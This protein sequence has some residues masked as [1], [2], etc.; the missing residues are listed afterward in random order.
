MA[1]TTIPGL[2]AE[3]AQADPHHVALVVHDGPALTYA[4]WDRRSNDVARG[5]VGR[6]VRP[7]DRV[8]LYFDNAHWID[9]AACYVGVHKAGAV[10]VP[11]SP[12]FKP[13][14]LA[15]ALGHAEVS[16]VVVP[17]DLRLDTGV[18]T[19]ITVDE[20][21]L[22]G[23]DSDAPDRAREDDLAEII[24]TSG[25][26]S[27]PKGVAC[28]HRNLLVHDLPPDT[29]TPPVFLHAFP[30]GTNAGQECLRI[31]LRRTATA[32]V[33]RVFDPDALCAA[34]DEHRVRRLQLVPSMAQLIV[35]S[36]AAA[37]HD[38]SSVA[39]VILSSSPAQPDLWG[40]LAAA[41]P[42]ASLFNAYAL[43]EGG[44]ARTLALYDPARP[45]SVGRPVGETELRIVD[46]AGDDVVAGAT[47][48]VWLRRPG[49]PHREYYKNPVAT[50]SAFA[51]DWLRTGDAGYVDG[52]GNLHLVDRLKD[53]IITGGLNVSSLEVERALTAHPAV[54]DA[55]VFGVPHLVLGQDVAAAVVLREDAGARSLQSFVRERLAEHKVPHRIFIV[56]ALPRNESGKVMKRELRERFAAA[57]S[58]PPPLADARDPLD[59]LQASI[60]AIWCDVLGTDRVAVDD[61]FFSLGGESLAATQVAARL[62]D[63]FE[64]DLPATAVFEHPTV[65]ELAVAVTQL[66]DAVHAT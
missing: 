60:A 47:G 10:A 54:A 29:P 1:P 35:D 24:Y 62:R 19:A 34:V 8:A 37:R 2:L 3:R 23:G 56:D 22:A 51:G 38:V 55:A 16:L 59:P 33:L 41:F 9:Y 66:R 7:G 58:A 25:T 27:D 49:A 5:L 57:E 12:R 30:V 11:V 6:G 45:L 28:T 64:V 44:A 20:L 32:V 26:T 50:A 42:N 40:R 53:V 21:A 13:A 48:E 65:A 18:F 63:S 4:E 17:N 39:R 43:T 14:E 61:D 52:D 46:E 31:P 15:T 36:G